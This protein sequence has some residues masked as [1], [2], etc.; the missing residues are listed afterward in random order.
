MKSKY[1]LLTIILF[2]L[3]VVIAI[4]PR[5]T[6]SSNKQDPAPGV[7]KAVGKNYIDVY[8]YGRFLVSPEETVSL[9]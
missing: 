5:N 2:L 8:G 6:E 3:F 9:C 4:H 1:K 7:I